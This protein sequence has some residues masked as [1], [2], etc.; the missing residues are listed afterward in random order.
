[1]SVQT[2][3]AHR[4]LLVRLTGPS[5]IEY[6]DTFWLRLGVFP[7]QLTSLDPV[8]VDRFLGPFYQQL[9]V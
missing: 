3:S 1:M 4:K 6:S 2:L 7:V 8:E 9:G 5:P